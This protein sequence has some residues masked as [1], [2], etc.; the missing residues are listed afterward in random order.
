MSF[1][2]DF[3]SPAP[4]TRGCNVE[5]IEAFLNANRKSAELK[6][7]LPAEQMKRRAGNLAT[8]ARKMNA[9]VKVRRRDSRVWLIRTDIE[10][11]P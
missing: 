6:M 2:F 7:E 10:G 3:E 9:S 5:I 11:T 4:S 1:E 8:R